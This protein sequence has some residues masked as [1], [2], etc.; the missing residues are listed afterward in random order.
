MHTTKI[1][2][3]DERVSH[4]L[5]RMVLTLNM[6]SCPRLSTPVQEDIE[7]NQIWRACRK[8]QGAIF[9]YNFDICADLKQHDPDCTGYVS[10]KR[11]PLATFQYSCRVFMPIL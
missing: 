1:K 8:I 10:G 4:G 3:G 6:P 9:R 7:L 11:Q 2:D 5:R